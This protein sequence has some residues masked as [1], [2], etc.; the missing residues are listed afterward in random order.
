MRRQRHGQI[1]RY[2]ARSYASW[3]AARAYV[4]DTARRLKL[5]APGNRIDSDGVKLVAASMA[6][7]VADNAMQVAEAYQTDLKK[8]A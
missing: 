1:Q 2:I 6:K 8:V 4:Y 3:K 5:N 7:E